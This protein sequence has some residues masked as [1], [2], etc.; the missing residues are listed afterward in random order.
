MSNAADVD[1]SLYNHGSVFT[2]VPRSNE[3]IE[4]ADENL[5]HAMRFGQGIAIEARFVDDIVEFI[6]ADGL[7]L[8]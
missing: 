1:F 3:A 6:Q 8:G 4:W 5:S 7:T 2:L